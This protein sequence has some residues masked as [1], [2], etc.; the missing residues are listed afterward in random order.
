MPVL[1]LLGVLL[2]LLLTALSS[3][4]V[5]HPPSGRWAW[6]G[7]SHVPPIFVFR[8]AVLPSA[9]SVLLLSLLLAQAS[10]KKCADRLGSVVFQ[11]PT[12]IL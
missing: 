5:T 1:C 7:L 3:T 11:L 6:G 8:L 9:S 2:L 12:F 10:W 4:K